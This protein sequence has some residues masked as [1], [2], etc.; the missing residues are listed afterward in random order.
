M[1]Q[2][3]GW[4]PFLARLRRLPLRLRNISRAAAAARIDAA[5]AMVGLSGFDKAYPRELSGGMKMR[6]SIARALVLRPALLW[7]DEPFAA[8]DEI[9]RLKLNNDLLALKAELDT[10]IVFV[11]HSVYESVYMSSRIAIFAARPGRIIETID[12]D[13]PARRDEDFRLSAAYADHARRASAALHGAM[14]AEARP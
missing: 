14:E 10:T 8:L 9:T 2:P 5:L 12:I 11:T 7:M 6:V 4:K 3:P 1:S 13:A